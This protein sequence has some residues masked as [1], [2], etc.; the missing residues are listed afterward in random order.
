MK[1]DRDPDYWSEEA[2]FKRLMA[3]RKPKPKPVSAAE[4]NRR[5]R[6]MLAQERWVQR[7]RDLPAE[8]RQRAIDSVWEQTLE[9]KKLDEEE[10]AQTC[11]VGPSDPDYWRRRR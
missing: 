7:Q 3:G 8:L 1:S 6:Q 10:A 5:V 2:I 9:A 4:H 11:H